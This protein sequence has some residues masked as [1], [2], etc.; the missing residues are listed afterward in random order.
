MQALASLLYEK[1]ERGMGT[2]VLLLLLCLMCVTDLEKASKSNSTCVCSVFS[3]GLE[4]HLRQGSRVCVIEVV[5][6][7]DIN[8][9]FIDCCTAYNSFFCVNT[10]TLKK[11]LPPILN[12]ES[13]NIIISILIL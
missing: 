6:Q 3:L 1:R 11:L 7:A 12:E 9:Q 5:V 4:T 8:L 10:C 2:I 13:I